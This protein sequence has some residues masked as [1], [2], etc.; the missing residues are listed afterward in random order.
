MEQ[1]LSRAEARTRSGVA[2]TSFEMLLRDEV[3]SHQM[4]GGSQHR[5]SE[6]HVVGVLRFQRDRLASNGDIERL[7]DVDGPIGISE[8]PAQQL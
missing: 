3:I 2:Q 5:F 8:E 7:T 6:C 1:V 4:T